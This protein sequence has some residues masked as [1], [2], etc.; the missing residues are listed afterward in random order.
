[1]QNIIIR[2]ISGQYCDITIEL[3]PWPSGRRKKKFKRHDCIIAH[4]L[5]RIGNIILHIFY[6]FY[7]FY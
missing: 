4:S 3:I 5:T 6:G 1:M 2:C 7:M